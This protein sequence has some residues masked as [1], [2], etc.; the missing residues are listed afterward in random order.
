LGGLCQRK[1]ANATVTH[2]ELF[3]ANVAASDALSSLGILT[4]F[5]TDNDCNE[6]LARSPTVAYGNATGGIIEGFVNLTSKAPGGYPQWTGQVARSKG[7]TVPELAYITAELLRRGVASQFA[8]IQVHDDTLTQTGATI[9]A[10][11]WLRSHAPW[12]VP[13]V[14]EVGGNS[15]PQTLHRSGLFIAAPEQYPLTCP[16]SNC[17]TINATRGALAQMN[18]YAGNAAADSRFGLH[19]WPLFQIGGG[20]GPLDGPN[21]P[22]KGRSN[23]RSD[24]LVRWMGYAAVAYGAKGLNW[25]CWG[26]G[27]Y[28][29]SRDQNSPGRPSPMYQTVREVNADARA[30]GDELLGG[31]FGFAAALHTGFSDANGGGSPSLQNV[32]VT[33]DDDLL[34][35]IFLPE[36]DATLAATERSAAAVDAY[37]FVVDKRVSGQLAPVSRRNASLW[38]HPSVGA[39][40]VAPPGQQGARGFEELRQRHGVSPPPPG[41]R[42]AHRAGVEHTPRGL[43]VSVELVGG[44]G[45]LVRL[46]AAP[47]ARAALTDACFGAGTWLFDVAA[48]GLNQ[49]AQANMNFALKAPSWAYDSWHS[50]Y[51]PYAGLEVTAGRSFEDGEQTGFLLGGSLVRP[52]HPPVA[53]AEAQAWAWAGFNFLALG[54]PTA[55]ELHNYSGAATELGTWL[56]DGYSFGYFVV[57]EPGEASGDAFSPAEVV[58]LNRKFRCHG[59]WGGLLLGRN[60]SSAVEQSATLAAA[61]ALRTVGRGSWLLP[62]ATA[63]SASAALVLGRG[64]VPLAMPSTPAVGGH[65]AVA[66]AQEVAGTY[67]PLWQ[68][69]GSSYEAVADT[70]PVQWRSNAHMG[71]VA[72]VDACASE[73]DSMLRWAAFSALAYG[74]RGLFWR[75]AAACAPVGSSRFGLLASINKRIAAWGNTFV[76]DTPLSDNHDGGYNVTKLWS[77]GFA[78]PHA[79]RPSAGATDLVQTADE[80]VLVA[81]LGSLGR[82]AT[83]LIYV[84]NQRVALQP[85]VAGL[86]TIQ[87]QLRGDVTAAQPIE[88]DCAASRCQCGLSLLGPTLSLSLPGGAGQLV[89]LAMAKLPNSGT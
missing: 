51:R 36:D 82:F 59:R 9:K 88:G 87:V 13:L 25:Y 37:L 83:P 5:N 49:K 60:V 29:Y 73:S 57:V 41:P 20:N 65:S 27:I 68:M 64:G 89:A 35:G 84:V 10:T 52:S 50:R 34:V 66:W 14:N 23:V 48:P 42:R 31:G 78:L 11:G 4:V 62:L 63:A 56:D 71:F 80:D 12:M 16:D 30:W 58:A 8:A 75:G 43:R 77:T 2:D 69:L 67:A 55:A 33:M 54:A 39:A 22:D 21:S 45:A 6:Q 28:W 18:L 40:S 81:E 38:L 61:A 15:G 19:H 72:A 17:S 24:S 86:R 47:G 7:T 26:G 46:T 70:W 79:A 32:V 85:G 76:A 53:A 44:G 1:G 74:A 3:D